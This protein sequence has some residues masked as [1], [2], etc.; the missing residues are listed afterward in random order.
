M[1][2]AKLLQYVGY[3]LLAVIAFVL[4]GSIYGVIDTEITKA[5]KTAKPHEHVLG[6][7]FLVAAVTFFVLYWKDKLPDAIHKHISPTAAN[8]IAGILFTLSILFHCAFFAYVY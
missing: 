3:F 4:Y 2:S 7:V 6:F 5:A 1:K 8:I